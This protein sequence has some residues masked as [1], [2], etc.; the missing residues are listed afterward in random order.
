[1]KKVILIPVL[2]LVLL[3]IGC[4]ST[5]APKQQSLGDQ[6]VLAAVNGSEN[7]IRQLLAMGA[8]VNSRATFNTYRITPLMN[9]V[10]G[11]NFAAVRFL[12]E[13]GADLNLRDSNGITALIHA[14]LHK[15]TAIVKYLVESG[16]NIDIQDNETLNALFYAVLDENPNFT[17]VKYIVDGGANVNLR[18]NRGNTAAVYAY[19]LRQMEIYNYLIK[20]NKP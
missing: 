10:I 6:L 9:A 17:I 7:E 2:A 1:M 16:A 13:Y 11:G 5:P 14:V 4:G 18:D 12:T 8:D 15:N 19:K 3:L 20:D